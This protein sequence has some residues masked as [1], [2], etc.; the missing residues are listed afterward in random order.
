MLAKVCDDMHEHRSRVSLGDRVRVGV[1]PYDLKRGSIVCCYRSPLGLGS[2]RARQ[3]PRALQREKE[4]L[5]PNHPSR[6]ARLTAVECYLDGEF[7]GHVEEAKD[8]VFIISHRGIR[9][10]VVLEPTFLKQC[11]DY[12]GALRDSDL[13]DYVRETRSQ[14]RRY[15]ST[16]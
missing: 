14:A 6:A 7:P 1:P 5:M 12:M 2:E 11:P 16:S 13:A 8:N 10:H 4:I 3:S 15:L 9:H